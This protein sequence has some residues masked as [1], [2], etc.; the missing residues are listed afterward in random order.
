MVWSPL[1]IGRSWVGILSRM[2]WS[3]VTLLLG[4]LLPLFGAGASTTKVIR[5]STSMALGELLPAL[6]GGG[7]SS[8]LVAEEVQQCHQ[9]SRQLGHGVLWM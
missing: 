1:G 4:G 8:T 5:L 6:G 3:R 7:V 2:A 9:L